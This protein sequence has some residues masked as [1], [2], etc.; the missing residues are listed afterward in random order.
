[1][2][3]SKNDEQCTKDCFINLLE[4]CWPQQCTS[5]QWIPQVLDNIKYF[6]THN[7][8]LRRVCQKLLTQ[9]MKLSK[10]LGESTEQEIFFEG[11]AQILKEKDLFMILCQTLVNPEIRDSFVKYVDTNSRT[12]SLCGY[13]TLTMPTSSTIVVGQEVTANVADS[14]ESLVNVLDECIAKL[15]LIQ[16][17]S[18]EK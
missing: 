13:G 10:Q 3:I 8:N 11:F 16:W 7:L 4:T 2:D 9:M 1:M 18:N 17:K 15:K 5:I 6:F 12:G 14:K